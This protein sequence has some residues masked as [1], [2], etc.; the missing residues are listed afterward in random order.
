MHWTGCT[1]VHQTE[2]NC[3]HYTYLPRTEMSLPDCTYLPWTEMH[4]T[5]FTYNDNYGNTASKDQVK[6]SELDSGFSN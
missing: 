4:C 6:L 1:Y 5:E 3:T 2:I